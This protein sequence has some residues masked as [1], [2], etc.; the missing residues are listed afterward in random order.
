MFLNGL[1]RTCRG[2]ALWPIQIRYRE[3]RSLGWSMRVLL[4]DAHE[5]DAGGRAGARRYVKSGFRAS[6]SSGA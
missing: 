6:I 5:A 1:L 3:R 2:W 4:G